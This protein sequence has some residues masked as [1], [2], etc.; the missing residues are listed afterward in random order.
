M[1]FENSFAGP[2]AGKK[3][4]SM[5]AFINGNQEKKVEKKPAEETEEMEIDHEKTDEEAID[6]KFLSL[7]LTYQIIATE[8]W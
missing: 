2:K 8:Q 4:T 1:C 3:Q 6:G 5:S 7:N